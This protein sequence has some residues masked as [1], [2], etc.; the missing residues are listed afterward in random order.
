LGA[1]YERDYSPILG[2]LNILLIAASPLGEIEL[3]IENTVARVESLIEQLNL[4]RR[5]LRRIQVTT[6]LHVSLDSLKHA[7]DQGKY[8]VLCFV[9]H[10]L[11]DK[12]LFD[13]GKGKTSV[14]PQTG[15]QQRQRGNTDFVSANTLMLHLKEQP[16]RLV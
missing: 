14:D 7:L 6:L 3:K 9:G 4:R 10:G 15:Q 11:P 1:S 2:T 13:D 16:I 8:H 12:L 5:W